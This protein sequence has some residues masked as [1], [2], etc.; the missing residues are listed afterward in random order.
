MT[1]HEKLTK[2]NQDCL[3]HIVV[4]TE[5]IASLKQYSVKPAKLLSQNKQIHEVYTQ[6][7]CMGSTA[8]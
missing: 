8:K 1:L 3:V 4:S 5:A 7:N 6:L 2:L